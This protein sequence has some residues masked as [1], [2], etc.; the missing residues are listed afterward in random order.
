MYAM[1]ASRLNLRAIVL[2]ALVVVAIIG[3]VVGHRSKHTVPA[4]KTLTA[5]VASVLLNYPAA[6]QQASSPPAI[7]GLP[8]TREL[9]LAPAGNPAHAGLLAGGLP[10]GEPSPLPA[11]FVALFRALPAAEV[12][13][14]L[15]NQAYRY[16]RLSVPG[17][18]RELTVY[19]IPNP[20]GEATGLAC[21][22]SPGYAA[23]MR[24]CEH[25]V[26]T[27]TLVGQ[28][29]SYDLTPNPTYARTLTASITA[30]DQQRVAMRREMAQQAPSL[31]LQQA[32]TRLAGVFSHAAEAL[33]A[34][35]PSLA[36]GRAQAGLAASLVRARDAY[37][38]FATAINQG[39][40]AGVT[41][42]R[43]LVY[44]AEASIDSALEGFALLGYKHA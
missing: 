2:P 22:A 10:G 14:F 18:G 8:I 12:V 5:S 34:L 23:D 31:A 17:F 6:W 35:E 39:G 26:A 29:Q 19:A 16:G 9:A 1:Y 21:Y 32:A 11:S 30:L 3:F 37:N 40:P 15:G 13:N 36:V 44:Q 7:P 42:A 28:S 20:G 24:T 27:L 4:E 38:A 33:S 25:I 41:A 43:Q